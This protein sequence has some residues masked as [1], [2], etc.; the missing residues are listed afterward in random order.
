MI[1]ITTGAQTIAASI[2]LLIGSVLLIGVTVTFCQRGDSTD[3]TARTIV[4][5]VRLVVLAGYFGG[6]LFVYRQRPPGTA[7]ADTLPAATR[8]AVPLLATATSFTVMAVLGVFLINRLTDRVLEASGPAEEPAQAE[9]PDPAVESTQTEAPE[10]AAV[11]GFNRIRRR[12]RVLVT[13]TLFCIGLLFGLATLELV[14]YGTVWLVAGGLAVLFAYYYFSM[15]IDPRGWDGIREPTPDERQLI[16]RCYDRF[17]QT[18]DQCV[19]F[20]VEER[21]RPLSV[22]NLPG[23]GR[24]VVWVEK[25]FLEDVTED[26]LTVLLAQADGTARKHASAYKTLYPGA[27]GVGAILVGW[28]L[29]EFQ[30]L[31]YTA[32]VVVCLLVVAA[33]AYSRLE[34]VT[35]AADDDASER[36]GPETVCSVYREYRQYVDDAFS[37][38]LDERLERLEDRIDETDEIAVIDDTNQPKQP[39]QTDAEADTSA[40]N[41]GPG[42]AVETDDN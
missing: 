7:V 34:T 11:S 20:A 30:S 29:L 8:D 14:P 4:D 22:T 3:E 9:V 21:W 24:P 27:F 16:E 28:T 15:Q 23:I 38:P 1:E 33:A 18:P 40:G 31:W 17:D 41:M 2:L 10:H 6:L 39:S 37:I 12:S 36:F 32:G 35:F 5:T 25:S 13:A 26:E 42:S 19:V